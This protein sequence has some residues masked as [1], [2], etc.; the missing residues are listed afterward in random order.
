MNPLYSELQ[1][2]L[3]APKD[4]SERLKALDSSPGPLGSALRALALYGLNL[5]QLTKLAN[6]IARARAYGK[7]LDPLVPFRLAVLSNSTIDL[8]VPALVASAARRGIALEVIQPSYDQ[9]AQEALTPGSKVNAAEPD[10][11]LFALD[12]RAL[13]L[14]LSLGNSEASAATVAGVMGYFQTLR[15]GI[16]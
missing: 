13:P 10:A 9:V 7:S 14:K 1:W 5:N 8:V 3:P 15:N 12:Y 16:K 11:V 6:A 4:F 2:L